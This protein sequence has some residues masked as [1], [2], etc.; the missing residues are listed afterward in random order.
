MRLEFRFAGF[1]GQGLVT[2]GV[3]LAE[4]A[5]VEW[6]HVL[7][8][9][10]YGPEARGGTSRVDVILSDDPI[11]FPKTR[12][13][14]ILLAMTQGACDSYHRDLREGGILI[15]DLGLVTA[16]SQGPAYKIPITGLSRS[17]FGGR[18]PPNLVALGALI[19]IANP[20][21]PESVMAGMAKHLPAKAYDQAL[22][23]F[24]VGLEA[25]KNAVPAPAAA[26]NEADL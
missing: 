4:A 10:S 5:V 1:G 25:G 6:N 13:I 23:A 21:D 11:H 22:V 18:T 12:K 8:S 15:V 14:D 19:S 24:A 3:I 16:P 7:C 26:N 9:Q 2:A 17:H 20:V